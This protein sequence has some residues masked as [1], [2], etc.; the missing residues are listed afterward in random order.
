MIKKL[1]E[2]HYPLTCFHI[3]EINQGNTSKVFKITAEEG[4]FILKSNQ[5]FITTK[6]EVSC[7]NTLSQHDLSPS[8]VSTLS[9]DF[10]FQ[11][12]Q[13]F[14]FLMEY[15]PSEP[16]MKSN[17]NFKS[18]GKLVRHT[19]QLLKTIDIDSVTDRF[20]ES[21]LLNSIK[22]IS[23]KEA[24]HNYLVQN[25]Y[26]KEE[27]SAIIHGDLGKWNILQHNQNIKLIDFAEA[28]EGDPC[29]DLA[30]IIDSFHLNT[31]ETTNLL[32]GYQ[33]DD[34]AF[35]IRLNAAQK[36]WHFRGILYMASSDMLNKQ[37]LIEIIDNIE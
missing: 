3:E 4:T 16:L 12:N 27:Q 25:D 24:L 36:K 21:L 31:E 9:N 23:I 2:A 10:C 14:Y 13:L 1:I 7:L 18:L 11:K 22:D 32:E 19:H 8:I 28:R 35:N 37:Q 15:V 5:S 6:T 33:I 29:F 17:I 20:E 34:S 30:A 26:F